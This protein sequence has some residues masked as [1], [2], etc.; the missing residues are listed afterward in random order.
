VSRPGSIQEKKGKRN[1]KEKHIAE[2]PMQ[3]K[4]KTTRKN[5]RWTGSFCAG[6]GGE[7][8][9]TTSLEETDKNEGRKSRKE[10]PEGGDIRRG[11]LPEKKK[12]KPNFWSTRSRRRVCLLSVEKKTRLKSNQ[13]WIKPK[14]GGKEKEGC[15]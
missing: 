7:E 4:R 3:I 10:R 2:I 12:K 1:R 6:G 9:V 14:R 11:G 5:V 15:L 13:I 8:N